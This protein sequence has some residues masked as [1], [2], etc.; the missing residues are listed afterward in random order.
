MN[1]LEALR[2]FC[3]VCQHGSFAGAAKDLGVS[4]TMVSRYVKQLE[5]QL[6]CLLLKRNT[7]KVHI[8][9]AGLSYV[10]SITPVI[11]EL[12]Q[13]NSRMLQFN[14]QPKG[15]LTVSASLEFGGQYL[16]PVISQYRQRYPEVEINVDLSNQPEDVWVD[17]IDIAL[18]VAPQ[19]PSASFIARPICQSRLALWASPDY[20]TSSGCPEQ[21]EDLRQH[22]LLFFSHSIRSDQWIF[23]DKGQTLEMKL[24][25][26]WQSNNGRLLNEAAVLGQGIIQAP[27]YS[28]A[29][30]V[31][32]GELVEIMP[33]HSIDKLTISA[34]YPHSYEFSISIKTFIEELKVYFSEHEI[35]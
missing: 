19:L 21:L 13:I 24:P 1:Q 3:A 10:R 6:G 22:Q 34:V 15:K 5:N 14:Q 26:A 30:Y 33:Q 23:N 8:T 2:A 18:R 20:I 28:V 7:R 16:A 11:S 4:P 17:K 35:D 27:S 12:E 25:W 31:K 9:Q 29:Q 32:K